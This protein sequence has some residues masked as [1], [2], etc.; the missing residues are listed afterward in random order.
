VPILLLLLALASGAGNAVA[1]DR[2]FR[3]LDVFDIEYAIDPQISP[4]GERVA[5][6]RQSM[7]ILGDRAVGAMADATAA[8]EQVADVDF[9][10]VVAEDGNCTSRNNRVVFDVNQTS[11]AQYL[12]RAFFPG[13][14]RRSR[15]VLVSTT[16]YPYD[17]DP[18]DP[19]PG[20][21]R[22]GVDRRRLAR[23]DR[24]RARRP[25]LEGAAG[26]GGGGQRSRFFARGIAD[27]PGPGVR[28]HR[29]AVRPRARAG[30]HGARPVR[31]AGHLA[32]R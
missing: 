3:P 10:H 16:T 27:R 6:V 11:T 22:S 24:E 8:W 21:G 9:V 17:D 2:N 12:A 23:R 4:D 5:Y 32:C 20:L 25:D 26:C 15:N 31:R 30:L 29:L 7:D 19:R 1:A 18:S 13:D 28:I 14:N